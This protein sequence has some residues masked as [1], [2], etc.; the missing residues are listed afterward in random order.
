MEKHASPYV[1]VFMAGVHNS[2]RDDDR[3]ALDG[4]HSLIRGSRYPADCMSI[5]D[6][7]CDQKNLKVNLVNPHHRVQKT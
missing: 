4:W 6:F 7:M 2:E 3:S 1:L 5:Q